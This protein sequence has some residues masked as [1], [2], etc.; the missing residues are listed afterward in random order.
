MVCNGIMTMRACTTG[1]YQRQNSICKIYRIL[2][3]RTSGDMGDG[4]FVSS[5]HRVACSSIHSFIQWRWTGE[6][7]MLAGK[8]KDN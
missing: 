1:N 2:A 4:I 3:A 7:L 6:W 8:N 5:I